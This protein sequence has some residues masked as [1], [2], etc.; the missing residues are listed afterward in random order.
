MFQMGNQYLKKQLAFRNYL[1]NDNEALKEYQT[2]KETLSKT[3]QTDKITYSHAKTDFINMIIQKLGFRT[4]TR[5]SKAAVGSIGSFTP[6]RGRMMQPKL[7]NLSM[8]LIS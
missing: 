4:D 7:V 8:Y 5:V 3:H 2:L 1:L 6:L